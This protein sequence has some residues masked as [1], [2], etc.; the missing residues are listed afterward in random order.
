MNIFVCIGVCFVCVCAVF[1][2]KESGYRSYA[3]VLG[4]IGVL[5]LAAL[6]FTDIA[7]ISTQLI[8]TV[9]SSGAFVYTDVVMKAFGIA[10]VVEI[11]TDTVK[12]FGAENIA[13]GLETAG[14]AEMIL[15]CVP[16]VSDLVQKAVSLLGQ[17]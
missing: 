11:S 12:E 5:I 4:A 8:N 1:L 17:A 2:I 9:Q 14:K 7:D 3:A 13:K 16:M 10:F 6:T 15:L